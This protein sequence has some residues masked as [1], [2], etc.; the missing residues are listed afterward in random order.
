MLSPLEPGCT[1]SLDSAIADQRHRYAAERV[2][3]HTYFAFETVA[4]I[5]H[6]LRKEGR[7]DQDDPHFKTRRDVISDL[8]H[9]QR[10][11]PHELWTLLLLQA[12]ETRL[13]QRRR[14][15][16]AEEPDPSLDHLVVE[17]FVRA[18]QTLP[19]SLSSDELSWHVHRA[20]RRQLADALRSRPRRSA[21]PQIAVTQPP[22]SAV[23]CSDSD[24]DD[25]TEVA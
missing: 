24:R 20:S 3:F 8:L 25:S 18:L 21:P 5:Q 9:A 2:D 16:G 17:T 15:L 14:A 11:S 22:P 1:R 23:A 13:I 6:I 19:H 4:D 12:F 10:E 7:R